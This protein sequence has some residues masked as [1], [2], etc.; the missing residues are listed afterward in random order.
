MFAAASTSWFSSAAS[1]SGMPGVAA[2]AGRRPDAVGAGDPKPLHQRYP[3]YGQGRLGR[4]QGRG[5]GLGHGRVSDT[6]IA[7]RKRTCRACSSVSSKP[8]KRRRCARRGLGCLKIARD[9]PDARRKIGL[10]S[11]FG[12]GSRFFHVSSPAATPLKAAGGV[13]GL[14]LIGE[15][16]AGC[17]AGAGLWKS[18]TEEADLFLRRRA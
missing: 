17:S 15:P 11:E 18:L 3:I 1:V 14:L 8:P 5:A 12:K 4:R 9:R 7:S 2:S 6:G 16:G 10:E 13:A